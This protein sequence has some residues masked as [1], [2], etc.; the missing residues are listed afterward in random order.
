MY[1]ISSNMLPETMTKLYSKNKNH[2]THD[3]GVCRIS[4]GGG[5]QLKNFWDFGYTYMPR[6]CEPLLGGFG[7]MPPQENF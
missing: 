1:K 2:H 3:S 4:Q 5:A 7:G 6:S